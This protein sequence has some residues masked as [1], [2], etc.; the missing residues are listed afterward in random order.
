MSRA[1]ES[2]N[3][4]TAE[5]RPISSQKLANE[6]AD[7]VLQQRS[8]Y[9]AADDFLKQVA[10]RSG[11]QQTDFI[12]NFENDLNKQYGKTILPNLLIYSEQIGQSG[13]ATDSEVA[14]SAATGDTLQRIELQNNPQGG[15]AAESFN[16]DRNWSTFGNLD[17][18]ANPISRDRNAFDPLDDSV[19]SISRNRN[20]FDPL[21]NSVNSIGRNRNAFDDSSVNPISRDRNAISGF[22]TPANHS[23]KFTLVENLLHDNPAIRDWMRRSCGTNQITQADLQGL[24][25]KRIP[26]LDPAR[27][28]VYQDLAVLNANWNN[29][30][31]SKIQSTLPNSNVKYLDMSKVMDIQPVP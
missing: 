20:A 12:N 13:H 8:P 30:E 26:N 14:L 17:N 6:V 16:N 31:F 4:A 19:N 25:S 9:A 10:L 5:V 28:S 21:D 18:S 3:G 24:L 22:D 15:A 29:P 7:L 27:E 2:T 11:N 23:A 1:I